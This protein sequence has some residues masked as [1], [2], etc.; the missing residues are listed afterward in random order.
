VDGA[1]VLCVDGD[2]GERREQ[3]GDGV[4]LQLQVRR[5]DGPGLE[6]QSSTF[7][8]YSLIATCRNIL[9]RPLSFFYIVSPFSIV[10]DRFH[11]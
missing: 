1:R 6:T 11:P 10:S 8:F 7:F 4:H 5:R 3:G 2:E 9:N